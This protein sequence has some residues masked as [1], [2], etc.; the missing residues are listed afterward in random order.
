MNAIKSLRLPSFAL[1]LNEIAPISRRNLF[2]LL[3]DV[4]LGFA[5]MLLAFCLRF[6]GEKFF[7]DIFSAILS[8]AMV[9][10]SVFGVAVATAG[11]PKRLWRH[12]NLDDLVRLAMVSALAIVVFYLAMFTINRLDDVPRSIPA[13]HWLLV[14]MLAGGARVCVRLWMSSQD[15][16]RLALNT[17]GT[18]M[19]VALVGTG[20][21]TSMFIRTAKYS[22][23]KP[24][25]PVAIF[26]T[27]KGNI[28]RVIE[29]VP[30]CGTIDQM[31]QCF[32]ELDAAGRKPRWLVIC[33]DLSSTTIAELIR[34]AEE[35]GIRVAKSPQ[36]IHLAQD[37]DDGE[38]LK[39][40]P[41]ELEDLLGRSPAK[42]DLAAIDNLLKDKRI[43]V[44]GAGGSIGSELCRMVANCKP[45]SLVL[46]DA[47]EFNLYSIDKELRATHPGLQ[48]FTVFAD[49][50]RRLTITKHF[51]S[52]RPDIVFHAAALK[53]VPMVEANPL[54][55]IE[56]NVIG[57]KNVV[58]SAIES[59]A[60]AMIMVSTDKAVSPT[61]VMGATKRF[62]EYYC[63]SNGG[64]EQKEQ[65]TRLITVR[66]GNVLGSSGSVVPLFQ[67]QIAMGGPITVTHPEITR[68]FMTIKEAVGLVLQAA[69]CI[70]NAP[71]LVRG[72]AVLDMGEPVKIYDLA[73][74]I[75][76]LSGLEPGKDIEIKSVGLR[77]GEK[78]YE[79]LFSSD[80]ELVPFE[81]DGIDMAI[82]TPPSRRDMQRALGVLEEAVRTRDADIALKTLRSIVPGY[83]RVV[84]EPPK[85]IRAA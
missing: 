41:I 26:D 39:L 80:E 2:V 27:D 20:H 17:D 58:D 4:G 48:I 73:C 46:L 70:L 12:A 6:G 37:G 82:S 56:T 24:Y 84:P 38:R 59:G 44:T 32:A 61:N 30:I 62:A 65:R 5:A 1:S 55:G 28:N 15:D 8:D 72:V 50:R 75:A 54:E 66:F 19:P 78:L 11:L 69:T 81:A 7:P 74:T 47:S 85:K 36:L 31:G 52:Y 18:S 3:V 10:G 53:H 83:G 60:Q 63:Q 35:F 13:L 51:E 79:E 45:S 21:R 34:K 43:L 33:D 71:D 25:Q 42:L 14:L 57:T 68:Y 23:F 16:R 22:G 9:F 29:N 64:P 67:Q 40:R 76:R 77:P 49:I